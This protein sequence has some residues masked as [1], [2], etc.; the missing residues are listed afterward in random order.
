MWIGTIAAAAT[1]AESA[2]TDRLEDYDAFCS[3][4]ADE[5]AYFDQKRTNWSEA[6]DAGRAAAADA[7][8]RAAFINVVERVLGEPYDSHAHLGTSNARSPRLVPTDAD[9]YAAWRDGSALIVDVRAAS[10]AANAGLRPGMRVITIDG[11]PVAEAVDALEPKHLSTPDPAARD[12]ALRVALAGRQDQRP[13]EVEVE[14]DGRRKAFAYVPDRPRTALLLETR[15]VGRIGV[16]TIRNSLGDSALIAAFDDALTAL[17]D[18]DGVVLDLRD[19]PSG[20]NTAV[21]RGI[22]GRLVSREAA[23]QRHE[24]ISE[25]RGSGVRHV[26]VEYVEPRG[27]TFDRP[28][29]VLVGRWTGSM[30]EGIAIGLAAARGAPVVGSPMAGLLGGLDEIRLPHAGFVV[31]IPTERLSHVDGRPREAFA[32]C[33]LAASGSEDETQQAVRLARGGARS[34]CAPTALS[35]FE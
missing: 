16:V 2:R 26:W 12:W 24:R 7:P 5:Y 28:I 29:V 23:Y 1:D 10:A 25:A 3:Y 6:C 22:M 4:V 8:D 33:P 21:A 32:P 15:R 11:R 9:L 18:A 13:V 17:R 14:A 35:R 19:T 34:D 30:G 27:W 31:R 20:G